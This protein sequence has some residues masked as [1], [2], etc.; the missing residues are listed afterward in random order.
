MRLT[1]LFILLFSA[2]LHGQKTAD[3][4]LLHD[5][6]ENLSVSIIYDGFSPPVASRIYA[7][8]NVTAYEALRTGHPKLPSLIA[9]LNGFEKPANEVILLPV[10]RQLVM[11]EAFGMVAK[12][13][14]YR[15]YYVDSAIKAIEGRLKPDKITLDNSRA[16]AEALH[17]IILKRMKADN[18]SKTRTMPKFTPSDADGTWRPTGPTFGDALEPYWSTV[19]T[20]VLDSPS[21]FSC[22]P[23][24]FSADT[25]SAFYK[26]AMDI[27]VVN[28]KNSTD[29]GEFV[30]FWDCNPQKTNITGHLMYK[31]RQLTP[32][33]HWMGI[34]HYCCRKAHLD[35]VSS[36]R[37][38]A[39]LSL[40]IADAFINCWSEKFKYNTIR[41]ETYIQR[42]IDPDW[43][44]ILETPLFPEFPSGHS[45]ISA[46]ASVILNKYFG[47]KFS[48][49]DST[50]ITFGSK[51]RAYHSFNEAADEAAMS[52]FY[53][54]IHFMHAC[55]E[56]KIL[57]RKVAKMVLM[58]TRF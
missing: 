5:L 28:K 53:G 8:C 41:P 15:Y 43:S 18:Y 16:T 49:I 10:D 7:Y 56:S 4:D 14:V 12:D 47:P 21:Q 26:E 9:K 11:L 50:E 22:T 38:Y 31:T 51:P 34:T 46:A 6:N 33:G 44:P 55:E 24:P 13:L 45:E 23:I 1:L 57:G 30:K 3:A 58:K 36:A 19:R 40:S 27:Y 42:Y 39:I 52:R 54:G 17:Q 32:G 35:L 25:H 37:V 29:Q 2:T 48:F 20:F